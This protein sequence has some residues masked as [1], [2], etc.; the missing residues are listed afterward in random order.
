[1][2]F[3]TENHFNSTVSILKKRSETVK[4]ETKG[5]SDKHQN[6][7]CL[8]THVYMRLVSG[9]LS[10]KPWKSSKHGNFINNNSNNIQR[11]LIKYFIT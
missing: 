1:M 9:D 4:V 6:T 7:H 3:H 10:W 2:S 11:D 8:V 5:L